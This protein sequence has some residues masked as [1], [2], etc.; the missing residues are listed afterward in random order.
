DAPGEVAP[1]C[2][3]GQLIVV[4]RQVQKA[5]AVETRVFTC[6]VGKPLPEIEALGRNRQFARVAVLLAAPSPVA[7]RLFGGD[8]ALFKQRKCE[9]A[10]DEMRAVEHA[11]HAAADDDDAC[12]SRQ[13]GAGFDMHEWRVH[14]ARTP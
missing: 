9:P 8:E 3:A 2:P 11:P 4:V 13:G 12:L 14:W 7:A 5:A 10:T 1:L 6:L